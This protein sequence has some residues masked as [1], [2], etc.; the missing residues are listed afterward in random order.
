VSGT[1]GSGKSVLARE[2]AVRLDA[3]HI[4]LD[5]LFHGP[6]WTP[7]PPDVFRSRVAEAIRAP[8]WV[9]DG[10]YTSVVAEEL[11]PAADTIIW[12]DY[13]FPLVFRRLF[14]RTLRR[15]WRREV[16]WNG[17]RERLHEHFL[18]RKSLFLW[19]VR[20]HWRRR[21]GYPPVLRRPEFA[22]LRV[23]RLRRPRDTERYLAS[24]AVAT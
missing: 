8:R 18:S 2:L 19:A 9:A 20:T 11:W 1:T 24:L 17:N 12:L 3:V 14:V 5:A 13:P 7:A 10:N 15:W 22:H 4:E 23:V 16:L 21:R 6:D